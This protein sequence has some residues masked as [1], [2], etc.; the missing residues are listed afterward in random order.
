[1]NQPP[2]GPLSGTVVVDLTRAL[3]GP[4][5][6]HLLAGL[7]A[8]VIKIEDPDGGDLSRDNAPYVGRDGVR[9][10]REEESDHSLSLLN[11]NRGKRSVTLNLKAAGAGEVFADLVRHA[12]VVIENYST[13]TA[14]RLG[15]G[16]AAARAAN[17][18]IVY[19]SINPYGSDE[20][21]GQRAMD[22][23]IQALSGV[24]LAGG[25]PDDPP[26]R[27]GFPLAD[28]VVALYAVIGIEAALLKRREMGT[29]QHIDVSMLGALTSLVAIEDWQ[30]MERLGQPLR[31]GPTLPRLAPF[32]LFPCADGYVTIVAMQDR[33]AAA[34][35]AAIGHPELAG[36]PR[37]ATRDARVNNHAEVDS[38]VE[39]WTMQH[40]VADVVD[41]LT[42]RGVPV[43]PVRDPTESVA[44]PR[45]VA[46][47]ETLPVIHPEFGE[48]EGLRTIGVPIVFS[49]DDVPDLAAAPTLGQHNDEVYGRLLGYEPE[50]VAQLR[51]GGVI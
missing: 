11:R 43:A 16:Y 39:A 15:V 28:A 18:S 7:G 23:I 13:G 33:L 46:R 20:P 41:R 3:A 21:D 36:D 42:E 31:T 8:D 27:V 22:T 44:D 4:L 10:N 24:M 5:G 50:R 40:S 25:A 26:M 38:M 19:C 2:A 37:F 14:E 30:A 34:V 51:R 6:T 48:I 47:G 12:D 9:L 35:F 1:V 45:V 29:G 49:E 17:E 32:G